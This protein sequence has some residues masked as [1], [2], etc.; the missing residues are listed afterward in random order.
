MRVNTQRFSVAIDAPTATQ[1]CE[2]RLHTTVPTQALML[3]N[4]EFVQEQATYFAE[5]VK[6]DAGTGPAK[7]IERA[8]W[9][10]LC[11]GP[12]AK[13]TIL[14]REFLKDHS[15]ADLCH[16]LFNLNEFVYFN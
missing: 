14:A 10:A 3:L 16:V 4:D 8:Y 5:R 2:R 15:L 9:L 11:R 12:T 7:Q 13:E 1:S 6:K